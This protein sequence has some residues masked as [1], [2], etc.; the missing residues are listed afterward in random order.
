[1]ARAS[2][3]SKP[4]V[5]LVLSALVGSGLVH[6]VGRSRGGKGPSAALYEVNARA[7]WVAGIDVGRRWVRAAIADIGGSIRGRRGE[8]TRIRSAEGLIAQVGDLAHGLAEEAGIEWSHVSHVTVGSPGVLDPER[9]TV[10]M[11]PNLPGWGREGLVDRLRDAL[12][13]AVSVENDVNLAALGEHEWGV[14]RG[15]D[16]F[17]Y[18]SVGTGIGLGLVLHGELYRGAHGAAGEIAYLPLG[19]GDPHDPSVRRRGLLEERAAAAGIVRAARDLGMGPPISAERVFAAARR[20]EPVASAAVEAEARRLAL[21][22][23]TVAVLLDPT[24]IVLGG[25][26]GR[27]GDLL[28]PPIERELRSLAPLHPRLAM[29]ALG[30][31]AVLFGAVAT[32]LREGRRHVFDR[33]TRVPRAAET[34]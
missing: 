25:G 6:E 34:P 15:V 12:G 13:T 4:T 8:R 17:A 7:G 32:A 1:V 18:L 31:D 11:A 28:L 20:G 3:L 33:H 30:E 2:G 27:S 16:D 22:I 14:G 5:S 24:L 26:V 29:S 19:G 23:A 10:A 21:A 9:Q